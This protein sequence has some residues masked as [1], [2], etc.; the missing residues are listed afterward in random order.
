MNYDRFPRSLR[1]VDGHS[2]GN[3]YIYNNDPPPSL[4]RL[5]FMPLLVVLVLAIIALC[6]WVAPD[7][8]AYD[9]KDDTECVVLRSLKVEEKK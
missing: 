8:K 9:C 6:Y 7:T 5:L 3:S 1:E 2:Y 4:A